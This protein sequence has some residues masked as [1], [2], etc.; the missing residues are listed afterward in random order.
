MSWTYKWEQWTLCNLGELHFYNDWQL[1]TW[2]RSLVC[3]CSDTHTFGSNTCSIQ[4][5]YHRPT[6]LCEW[7][8]EVTF[9]LCVSVREYFWKCVHVCSMYVRGLRDNPTGKVNS[10]EV[11]DVT[12]WVIHTY[13]DCSVTNDEP[14]VSAM[15]ILL[16]LAKLFIDISKFDWNVQYLDGQR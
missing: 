16:T 3:C 8:W 2:H 7:R 12:G 1:T 15:T 10:Q 5:S 13:S 4:P 11:A 14:T 9:R 6:P